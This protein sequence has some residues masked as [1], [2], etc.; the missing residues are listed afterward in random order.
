MLKTFVIFDLLVEL[1]DLV[2][3]THAI[4]RFGNACSLHVVLR[5]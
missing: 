5:W 1:V 3:V 4:A 2:V